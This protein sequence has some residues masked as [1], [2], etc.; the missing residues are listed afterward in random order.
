MASA[1]VVASA[2]RYALGVARERGILCV[3]SALGGTTDQLAEMLERT[4]HQRHGAID[5]RPLRTRHRRLLAELVGAESAYFADA[6]RAIEALFRALAVRLDRVRRR[7]EAAPE[8]R[9]TLLAMGERWA[10]EILRAVATR[11]AAEEAGQ[12][13]QVEIDLLDG[14]HWLAAEGSFVDARVELEATAHRVARW[15]DAE[16]GRSFGR[17]RLWVVPGFYGTGEDGQCR[18]LGRGGSDTSATALG[19]AIGAERVEIWTDVD[20]VYPRDPRHDPSARPFVHLR[21]DEAERLAMAGAEVLHSKSMAPAR[22]GRVPV[23]VCN[24]FR[25]SAAGTWIGLPAQTEVES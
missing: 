1:E 2:A 9:A 14:S 8:E 17:G 18:L 13:G 6:S 3:V 16:P 24:S 15:L 23:R 5:L 25:P 11:A 19:A 4:L 21:F 10:A 20:G 12:G 7:G 22:A